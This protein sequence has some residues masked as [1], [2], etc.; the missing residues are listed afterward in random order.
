MM[1]YVQDNDEA[2]P[3]QIPPFPAINVGANGSIASNYIPIE[4]QLDP[5]TKSDAIW[6]CPSDA[7]A[8]NISTNEFWDGAKKAN[9]NS[10]SYGYIGG[11]YTKETGGTASDQNTGAAIYVNRATPRTAFTLAEFDATADTVVLCEQAAPA[12]PVGGGIQS[13]T[14]AVGMTSGSA[15]VN[16]DTWKLAGRTPGDASAAP[17]GC[18]ATFQNAN[19]KPFPGHFAKGNYA[20]ADGHIKPFGWKQI[21][22]FDFWYFKRKKPTV[23]PYAKP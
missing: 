1:M 4:A 21:S 20:F 13:A 15:F 19:Y 16:C 12:Y 5:Y 8:T 6:H 3:L 11:I 9:P 18:V 14:W 7:A 10:R 2:Y 22:D 17:A 23:A